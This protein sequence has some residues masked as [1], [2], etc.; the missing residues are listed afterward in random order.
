MGVA[1]LLRIVL[2]DR[3]GTL[4]E[5]AGALGRAD[6]DILSID[7]VEHRQDGTAVDDV[8]LEL[9]LGRMVDTAVSACRSVPGVHVEYV[10]PYPAGGSMARDLEVVEAMTA[11]PNDAERILVEQAPA[12]FR[13]GW[14]VL[15][16]LDGH[17]AEIAH[18]SAGAPR[19]D[20]FRVPWEQ[21]HEVRAMEPAGWAP[22]SWSGTSLLV[23]PLSGRDRVLVIGRPSAIAPLPSE[24]ARVG[25]LSTL[26]AW[27]RVAEQAGSSGGGTVGFDH[28]VLTV[29]DVERSVQWYERVLGA[30]PVTF[31]E[32]RRAVRFGPSKI[33]FH[34]ADG[35]TAAPV[36]AR[37]TA[38]SGDLCVSVART[39]EEILARLEV[40][41]VATEMARV[42]RTGAR[43]PMTSVYVRD[44][45][46]NLVEL[47]SYLG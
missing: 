37:P 27:L 5:V 47:A 28:V 16:T 2:P 9:P 17:R 45:D 1:Y 25:Y 44:P 22:P 23:A 6:A 10:E 38:G 18:A 11:A 32:D 3:P 7:V 14:A 4:G 29:A 39:P 15:L 33:N 26:A 40:L 35:G 21:L 19:T 24:R 31:G 12:L 30:E 34:P 43:G 46:G 36:A 13:F 20:G 41:G 8:L 42:R